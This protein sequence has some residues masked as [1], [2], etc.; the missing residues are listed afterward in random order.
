MFFPKDDIVFIEHSKNTIFTI[1]TGCQK[2]SIFG[3]RVVYVHPLIRFCLRF[4]EFKS[5]L[6]Y[7]NTRLNYIFLRNKG[8]T[9][10]NDEE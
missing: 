6:T 2:F 1:G 9:E 10:I 8:R 5:V 3:R 4:S 7:T